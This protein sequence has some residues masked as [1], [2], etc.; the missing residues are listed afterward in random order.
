M[1]LY[2]AQV[3]HQFGANAFLPYSVGCLWAYAQTFPHIRERY[4]LREMLCLREPIADVVQRMEAAPPDV[5]GVSVYIWNEGYSEALAR[6]VKARWPQCLVV[7]GG[8]QV[9]ER[10]TNCEWADVV[11]A[12]EGE[13]AFAGILTTFLSS[14][15]NTEAMRDLPRPFEGH[16]MQDLSALPSPYLGGVF[17]TL[18]ARYDG[19][20][21]NA[22]QE[23]HR[24]CPYACTYCDWGSAVFQKVRQFPAAR[25]LGEYEWM[26]DHR[27]EL[28][29][30][31][32][33]NFALFPRDEHLIG[34]L[35]ETKR[36]RGW[37]KQVRAAWAK[38]SGDRVFRMASL[39][40]EA[41]MDKGVTLALQSMHPETLRLIKR[42]NIPMESFA[43]AV[44]QYNE[45]GIPTYTEMIL[46]L[47]GETY[48]TFAD[49]IDQIL[50]AG[51]HNGLN[52]YLCAILEN[53]EMNDQAYRRQ[54]GLVT[55]RSPILQQ[56]STPK[57]DDIPEWNEIVIGTNM[58]PPAEWRRTYLFAWAIQAFHTMG[59]TQDLAIKAH[60]G[61]GVSYR[62]FYERLLEFAQANRDTTL[63]REYRQAEETVSRGMAG[64]SWGQIGYG[65]VMWPLEEYTFLNIVC[66]DLT[67]FYGQMAPWGGTTIEALRWWADQRRRQMALVQT[68]RDPEYAG[69]VVRFAREQVWY[70]RKGKI[71]RK[72]VTREMAMA[73]NATTTS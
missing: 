38:N 5:L 46:G 72:Q 66:G 17:D 21:W 43:A 16:R 40:H 34:Q 11:V 71:F 31:A 20:E 59:L 52:L 30:N 1:N 10:G 37:P 53:A 60:E 57:A 13:G 51:Q 48:D 49:G 67:R 62:A 3:N 7:A 33:A 44:R 23:T 55:V 25:I 42:R 8:P 63:G 15:A 18:M 24:G 28:S 47:P 35:V 41:G 27:I 36:R 22:T 12:H 14:E 45:A 4:E 2:L 64:G 61:Q 39:L 69:D 26:A 56:H 32:D 9:A 50:R 70:G 29:Y 68:P 58:M 19:I 73:E 6:A 54:H 65:G